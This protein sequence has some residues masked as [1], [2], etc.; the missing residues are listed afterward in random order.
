MVTSARFPP[1]API[2]ADL[3]RNA[4]TVH[5]VVIGDVWV[6]SGQS[7][8]ELSMSRVRPAYGRE[9]ADARNPMIRQFLVPQDTTSTVRKAISRPG[10]GNPRTP[11]PF[12]IFP[13]RVIFCPGAVREIQCPYRYHQYEPRRLSR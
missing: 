10:D 7:N 11:S 5:D 13:L 3:G 12:S 2:D 9:I 8:M 4:L 6:C 1:A